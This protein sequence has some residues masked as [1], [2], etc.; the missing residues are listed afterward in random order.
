MVI[1]YQLS[2]PIG[3]HNLRSCQLRAPPSTSIRRNAITKTGPSSDNRARANGLNGFAQ[4]GP[5]FYGSREPFDANNS[6]A[7]GGRLG[8]RGYSG[9][10]LPLCRLGLCKSHH[11]EHGVR[12]DRRMAGPDGADQIRRPE[13]ARQRPEPSAQELVKPDLGRQTSDLGKFQRSEVR[14]P[15]SEVRRPSHAHLESL[16]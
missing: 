11:A 10:R 14:G 8:G 15:T 3:V 12:A 16:K 5:F 2:D 6:L 4:T 13:A 7:G 1:C 9:R